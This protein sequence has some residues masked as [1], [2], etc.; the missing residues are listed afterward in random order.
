MTL[1]NAGS[2]A[3][4]FDVVEPEAEVFSRTSRPPVK[5]TVP[6]AATAPR[7]L[8]YVIERLNELALLVDDPDE[9]LP[10]P[11]QAVL[12]RALEEANRL[13]PPSTPTPSVVPTTEG[14]VQFVWHKTGWDVEVEIG[15]EE[16][17]VW[18]QDRESGESWSGSLDERKGEL[19]SLL[20]RMA[21]DLH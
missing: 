5:V 4:E 14:H 1:I 18:A 2:T 3:F 9:D 7:W 6:R 15:M 12:N 19:V 17:W 21:T 20:H 10:A 13:L 16:T 11:S 8:S